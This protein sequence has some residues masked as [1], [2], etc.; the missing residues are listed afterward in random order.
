MARNASQD[1]ALRATSPQTTIAMRIIDNQRLEIRC[2]CGA[3][4]VHAIARAYVDATVRCRTCR[5]ITALSEQDKRVLQ[6][7][8]MALA[9]AMLATGENC[10]PS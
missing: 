9:E 1:V 7:H 4:G 2:S 5:R 6:E 10:R 3:N 8:L